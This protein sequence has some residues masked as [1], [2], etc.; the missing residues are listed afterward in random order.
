L[1]FQ[2][3]ETDEPVYTNQNKNYKFEICKLKFNTSTMDQSADANEHQGGYFENKI[4]KYLSDHHPDLIQNQDDENHLSKLTQ[5][6]LTLFQAYDRAGMSV[7]EAMERALTETLES[8]NSPYD[9]LKDFLLENRTFLTY[10]TGIEDLDEQDLVMRILIEN[11]AT[12]S[13][14]RMATAPED[15]VRAN[16]ELLSGVRKTLRSLNKS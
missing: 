14:F 11:T 16:K 6:A 15:V 10:T 1:G 5:D 12:L 9:I 13:A 2:N 3:P 7:Y 8:I 4:K